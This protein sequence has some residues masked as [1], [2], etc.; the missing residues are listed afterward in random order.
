[1]LDSLSKVLTGK[2]LVPPPVVREEM[3]VREMTIAKHQTE[4]GDCKY[5]IPEQAQVHVLFASTYS[6]NSSGV[7]VVVV[8]VVVVE[9]ALVASSSVTLIVLL[10]FFFGRQ[11]V[12]ISNM[13]CVSYGVDSQLVFLRLKT[14]FG[15]FQ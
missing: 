8:A 1:M 4:S 9:D 6:F 2:G 15:W 3:K 10:A 7:A 12:Q 13:V 11:T 5:D 14:L